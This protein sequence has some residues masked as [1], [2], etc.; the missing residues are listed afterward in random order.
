MVEPYDAW[1]VSRESFQ[2]MLPILLRIKDQKR[3]DAMTKQKLTMLAQQEAQRS[4]EAKQK[5][6]TDKKNAEIKYAQDMLKSA[7][8]KGDNEG[9]KTFGRFLSQQGLTV[10]GA[11]APQEAW[12]N[13]YRSENG[14]IIQKNTKTGQ[15]RKIS[16]PS[17]GMEITTG[18]GTTIRTGVPTS[19]MTGPTRNKVQEKLMNSVE[20]LS[21]IEGII[22]D[23]K[24][25]YQQ[26]PSKLG[27]KWTELKD[28]FNLGEIKDDDRKSLEEFSV[29]KQNSL[30]NINLYIKEIT[31][32]QMSEKEAT[33]I[34]QGLPDPGENVFDGDS[35][36][37][38]YSKMVNTYKQTKAAVARYNYYLKKG[39][40]PNAIGS[41]VN[42]GG[43]VS[44]TEME[45]I[46]EERGKELRS[47]NPKASIEEV[48]AMIKAE[49]GL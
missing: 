49:F 47:K 14:D 2:A 42:D 10:P 25:E 6:M 3:E 48:A 36:T 20:G 1:K 44:L 33:R 18:D 35:P 17:K 8:E 46:I 31:G 38:F 4:A 40:D 27:F 5:I 13:P 39:I 37:E 19:D 12:S 45:K 21:R 41:M 29:Y 24:P 26:V 22:K 34:R 28:K 9:V 32:A 16:S 7:Y 23:F 43:A 11:A 30:N 15:I